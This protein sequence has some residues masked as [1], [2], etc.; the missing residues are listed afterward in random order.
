MN[1]LQI[2]LRLCYLDISGTGFPDF[3]IDARL[4]NS[5]DNTKMETQTILAPKQ[6]NLLGSKSLCSFYI[7]S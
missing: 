7:L 5:V 4:N 3:A 6:I 1:Y 2:P